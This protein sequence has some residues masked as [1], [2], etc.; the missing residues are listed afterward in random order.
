MKDISICKVNS[1]VIELVIGD[2]H[3]LDR[4]SDDSLIHDVRGDFLY[5]ILVLLFYC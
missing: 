5:Q 4:I 2:V 3:P 1:F